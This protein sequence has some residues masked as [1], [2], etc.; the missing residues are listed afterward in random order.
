MVVT[1]IWPFGI[2]VAAEAPVLR[3][4]TKPTVRTA[5]ITNQFLMLFSI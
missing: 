2:S 4:M 3:Q 5:Q 1:V